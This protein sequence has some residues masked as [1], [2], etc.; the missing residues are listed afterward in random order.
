MARST[1]KRRTGS[2]KFVWTKELIIFLSVL[3]VAIAVTIF[4][5]VPSKTERFNKEW[6]DAATAQSVTAIP[7]DNVFEYIDYD[8]LL[9]LIE[10]TKDEPLFVF[11][12]SPADA[13]SVTNIITISD[14]SETYEVEK[15]YILNCNFHMQHDDED[16]D[17]LKMIEDRTEKLQVETL[18]VYSQFWVY[19]NGKLVFNS[20][21]DAYENVTFE[22]IV[23]KC[24]GEFTEI[25]KG[26]TEVK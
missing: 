13:N 3:L 1:A 16:I 20:D 21:D 15:V 4:C 7:N 6:Q 12:A 25:G 26:A 2:E 10:D 24:Y 11:Y 19:E 5:L 9:D 17:D 23:N 18:E 14:Y 22:W 8:D